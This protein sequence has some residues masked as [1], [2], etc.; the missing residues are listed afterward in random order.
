MMKR[1]PA[2]IVDQLIAEGYETFVPPVK[3]YEEPV[4]RPDEIEWE[5]EYQRL[6]AHHTDE[7]DA[8]MSII[9]EMTR[10]LRPEGTSA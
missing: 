6:Y 5:D 9:R 10:R 1:T 2:E 8:L 7:A 4:G 3:Q